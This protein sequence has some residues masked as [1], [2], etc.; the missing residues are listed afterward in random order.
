VA[1]NTQ[2]HKVGTDQ[3]AVLGGIRMLL[4]LSV[5]TCHCS[6]VIG[7]AD[8]Q[9]LLWTFGGFVAVVGF[10]LVSGYSI[11]HSLD[12]QPTG[13]AQRRIRRLVPLY[14]AALVFSIT[15]L[16]FFAAPLT[17]PNGDVISFP[18]PSASLATLFLLNGVL[19]STPLLVHPLW[20]LNCEAIYY[21]LASALRRLP[22]TTLLLLI[23][24][25][26]AGYLLHAGHGYPD[27]KY[28]IGALC[29]AWAWLTGIVFYRIHTGIFWKAVLT[30]G[31]VGLL[32]LDGGSEG[33][34]T[35]CTFLA[36]IFALWY[37][38]EVRLTLSAA[39]ILTWLGEISYPLYVT[40]YTVLILLSQTAL[41]KIG[42]VAVPL[43][44]LCTLSIATAFYYVIDVPLRKKRRLAIITV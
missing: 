14:L 13:F 2:P 23:V 29:L 24:L 9:R 25:S 10:F 17:L 44:W 26:G 33:R 43:I 5:V 12:V 32:A 42:Y 41:A 31:G 27:E 15:P 19:A 34:L 11:A 37:G 8:P 3:W 39:R 4:A 38:K 18:R 6:L 28:G 16:L 20:S 35:L 36:V 21:C 40:H 7:R 30:I 22:M 1:A